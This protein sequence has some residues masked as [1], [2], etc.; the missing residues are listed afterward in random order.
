MDILCLV[1]WILNLIFAI[2]DIIYKRPINPVASICAMLVCII[3]YLIRIA[4]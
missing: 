2:I 1:I 4:R 3:H